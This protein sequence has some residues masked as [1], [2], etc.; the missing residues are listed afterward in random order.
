MFGVY[1]KSGVNDTEFNRNLFNNL[2]SY[3]V[4]GEGGKMNNG[5]YEDYDCELNEY[6]GCIIYLK[7]DIG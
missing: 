2:G 6:E 7:I 5:K 4:Y 1:K 3:G